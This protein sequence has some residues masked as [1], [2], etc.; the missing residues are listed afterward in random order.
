MEQH[1]LDNVTK[2]QEYA[3]N[4]YIAALSSALSIRFNLVSVVE[5]KTRKDHFTTYNAPIH[6]NCEASSSTVN[7]EEKKFLFT[8]MCKKEHYTILYA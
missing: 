7:K 3:E 8:L 2:M 6:L 4:A 1:C 5:P